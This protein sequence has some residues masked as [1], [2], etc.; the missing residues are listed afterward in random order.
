MRVGFHGGAGKLQAVVAKA[1]LAGRGGHGLC[2]R[3]ELSHAYDG[4][5]KALQ[6]LMAVKV[7]HQPGVHVQLARQVQLRGV[8]GRFVQREQMP[9]RGLM[10]Q[11]AHAQLRGLRPAFGNK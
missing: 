4:C 10:V 6:G 5:G 8:A 7:V 2:R 9:L 11:V 1:D 3:A